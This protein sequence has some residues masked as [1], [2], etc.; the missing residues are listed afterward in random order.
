RLALIEAGER[1][2]LLRRLWVAGLAMMQVMMYAYPAYIAADGEITAD[3]ESLMRWAGFALTVP[4]VA[5]SAAPF[6]RGAWRDLRLRNLG[7]EVPIALGIAVAFVASMWNT[8]AGHGHVYFDSVT[9][10]VFLLLGGRYLELLA[11]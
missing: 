6:F 3:V 4:V 7:M 8:F 10:F 1:R 2:S 11:R 9:M 5:Y